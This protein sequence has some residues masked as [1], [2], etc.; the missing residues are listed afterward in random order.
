MWRGRQSCAIQTRKGRIRMPVAPL[1]RARTSST[2]D[3]RTTPPPTAA[4]VATT[5]ASIVAATP[6]NPARLL[7]S[8]AERARDS[9]SGTTSS[10]FSAW[11]ARASRSSPKRVSASTAAGTRTGTPACRDAAKT[12]LASSLSFLATTHRPSLSSTTEG[13]GAGGAVFS[14]RRTIAPVPVRTLQVTLVPL[15]FPSRPRA[16]QD[17]PAPAPRRAV[18]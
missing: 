15:P 6:V 7:S 3:V 11:F 5:T 13:H 18:R 1:A 16:H 10:F 4:E 14:P 8:A 12:A 2:S 9:V 17:A